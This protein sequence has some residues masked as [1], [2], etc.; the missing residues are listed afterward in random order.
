MCGGGSRQQP[1]PAPATPGIVNVAKV[2]PDPSKAYLYQGRAVGEN[3]SGRY[4][5]TLL[6]DAATKAP[7][8]TLGGN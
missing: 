1:P 6:L 2:A 3:T 7:K 5:G 8:Q 4:G